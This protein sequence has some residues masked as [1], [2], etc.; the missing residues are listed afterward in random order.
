MR[1]K[2]FSDEVEQMVVEAGFEPGFVR[3]L[4]DGDVISIRRGPD[5]EAP[6]EM[7]VTEL[8][9]PGIIVRTGIGDVLWI[10]VLTDGRKVHCT[11]DARHPVW[12]QPR[13]VEDNG[14]AI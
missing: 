6:T 13:S 3:D 4:C 5:D 8:F 7:T 14:Q 11:Y 10:G 2:A 12:R 1:S 9:L